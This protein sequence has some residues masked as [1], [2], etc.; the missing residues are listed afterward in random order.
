MESIRSSDE[1]V[2]KM[3][4]MDREHSTR[5]VFIP[6]KGR[7]VIVLQEEDPP[8]IQSEVNNDPEMKRM[9]EASREDYK[10]GNFKTTSELIQSLSPNEFKDH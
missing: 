5:Q 10:K 6:G 7:F 8:S 9:I 3:K 1:L 2:K 4:E